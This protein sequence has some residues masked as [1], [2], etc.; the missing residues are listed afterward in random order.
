MKAIKNL[1]GFGL[2][3]LMVSVFLTSCGK[4]ETPEPEAQPI[5][6][7]QILARALQTH[8]VTE[9]NTTLHG[10]LKTDYASIE[11]SDEDE[12]G[13]IDIARINI[14]IDPLE[15]EATANLIIF[16][17]VDK[18]DNNKEKFD[19]YVDKVIFEGETLAQIEEAENIASQNG[20]EID[21]SN[22]KFTG[23]NK[24]ESH[25]EGTLLIRDVYASGE[26]IEATVN[27]DSRSYVWCMATCYLG[28]MS[29]W[30]R[31]RCAWATAKCA[32]T[33]NWSCYTAVKNCVGKWS[34][35]KE[36]YNECT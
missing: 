12:D 27:E 2:L 7:D 34:Y 1:F 24:I 21:Y 26:L 29:W 16:Y 8:N 18:E 10:Q 20:T 32:L 5:T 23:V 30:E 9:F 17:F 36:C 33:R 35:W 25:D 15:L 28:K 31:S 22:V 6:Q 4:D 19:S 11:T 13:H 14:P 3:V